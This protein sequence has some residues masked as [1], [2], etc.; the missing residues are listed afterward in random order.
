[1]STLE[2]L[3]Q[4]GTRGYVTS[5]A[6]EYENL[7]TPSNIQRLKGIPI[8]FFS[9]GDNAIFDPRNTQRSY[10]MLCEVFGEKDYEYEVFEGKGHLDCWIGRDVVG[11]VY[12]R[13]GG[14]VGRVM[15]A[16]YPEH[17]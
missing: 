7:V 15:V 14:H 5:N 11:D 13:V 12:G 17:D 10:E 8:F 9:G 4:M 1:M 16:L 6:P 3:V 2:H